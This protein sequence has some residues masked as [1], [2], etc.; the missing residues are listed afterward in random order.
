MAQ[1]H[2]PYLLSLAPSRPSLRGIVKAKS[3]V[4]FSCCC[5]PPGVMPWE[6]SFTCGVKRALFVSKTVHIVE[7]I[8]GRFFLQH[9]LALIAPPFPLSILFTPCTVIW[10]L[11]FSAKCFPP[12]IL[13]IQWKWAWA[14]KILFQS[15]T[16]LEN[17]TYFPSLV[18]C[19]VMNWSWSASSVSS[20]FHNQ[21]VFLR[22]IWLSELVFWSLQ[23]AC[24]VLS[25]GTVR[26]SSMLIFFHSLY[27]Y[28]VFKPS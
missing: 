26:T 14:V 5:M 17:Q 8:Q 11:F 19:F 25:I 16:L 1:F 23:L 27:P 6:F 9:E 21:G 7:P 2:K 22:V 15:T 3:S 24:Y 13:I 12:E 10:G 18:F 20:F 4:V 28:I